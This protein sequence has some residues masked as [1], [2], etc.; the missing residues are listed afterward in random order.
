MNLP[1]K[2]FF[3]IPNSPGIVLVIQDVQNFYSKGGKMLDVHRKDLDFVFGEN[4]HIFEALCCS[5]PETGMFAL[6]LPTT[7][8]LRRVAHEVFHLTLR[9]LEWQKGKPFD[10]AFHEDGAYLHEYL[11]EQTVMAL[12]FKYYV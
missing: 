9:I 6:F 7:A 10:N 8:D 5:Q 4:E 12:G 1:L 2:K 11:M 3:L